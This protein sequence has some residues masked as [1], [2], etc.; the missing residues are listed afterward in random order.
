M[1]QM[2]R[3]QNEDDYGRICA[4]L[5]QAFLAN[6]R[7]E[8]SWQVARL[9]YW[10]WHGIANLGD[11][12]LE[13]DVFLWETDDGKLVAVLNRESAG[14]AYL[15]LHPAYR[16]ADL[17]DEMLAV[18]ERHLAV[19][20]PSGRRKLWV[21]Y[22]E[23]DE[24][25][26]EALLRRGYQRQ[27]TIACDHQ[28]PLSEP[29]PE[30]PIAARYTVRSLAGPEDLPKKSWASWRAFHPEAPAEEYGGWEWY[31]NIQRAPLYRQELDLVAVAPAGEF[32]AFCTIWYDEM[33]QTAYY[34]PVGTVPEHQRRGLGTAVLLE[35]LRRLKKLGAVLATVGSGEPHARTFYNAI[36]FGEVDRCWP[37]VKEV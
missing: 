21:M 17:E 5:R 37:W 1:Y 10:R 33:T 34:E 35:G 25:R 36:G 20:A 19:V 16:T 14:A 22:T 28:R 30:A 23:G 27:D 11:G 13:E 26:R 18:A 12:R 15:Q 32:A 31:R 6:N 24:L 2:R 3:Y 4:L 9:D 7:R 8:L 29:I